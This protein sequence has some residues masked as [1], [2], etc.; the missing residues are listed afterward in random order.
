MENLSNEIR[1]AAKKLLEEEK[2]DLVI[3][4]ANGSLP[5][6]AAPCFV[7]NAGD[8]DKLVWN[9]MCENNLAVYLPKRKEKIAIVAKGCDSRSIIGHIK[10]GQIARENLVIIGVP[11]T[12]MIDRLKVSE[13][14][15]GR[16]ILEIEEKPD[17]I[18]VKGDGFEESLS[19]KEFVSDNCKTCTHRNPVVNDILIGPEV[20][21]QPD[22]DEFDTVKVFEGRTSDERWEYFSQ[23]ADKC[24]RCYA[25]R[26]ACPLCYCE[27]CAVDCSQ[28][29]WFGKSPMLADT[30]IFHIM[31]ALH[32]AGRCVDCGACVRA[33]P[34]DVDLRFFNK[35]ID[36]DVRELFS[37]EAGVNPDDSPPLNTFNTDDFDEFIKG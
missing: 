14:T 16:D 1:E 9:S 24:I 32:T 8:T 10:E 15:G 28:P 31:R 13:K 22:A 3:G 27:E 21:E 29:Q 23:I 35:K 18:V 4:F 20:E 34:M 6:R 17:G 19:K 2:V 25:C 26:N 11:C 30:Q 7:R 33:C 5:L 12:G 36:K 37:Y